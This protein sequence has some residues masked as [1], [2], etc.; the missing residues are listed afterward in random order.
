MRIIIDTDIQAII[1][2]DSYYTQVDRLNEIIVEAGGK[3]LDHKAYIRTCFDKAY[4]A[5]IMRYSDVVK[6]KPRKKAKKAAGAQDAEDA[7]PA[8]QRREGE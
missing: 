4:N 2:P 1:V 8:R 5:R 7:S 6:L 3:K